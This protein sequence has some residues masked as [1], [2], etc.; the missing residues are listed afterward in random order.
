M[1]MITSCRR[2][3][4]HFFKDPFFTME[5]LWFRNK[6]TKLVLLTICLV[7]IFVKLHEKNSYM[8]QTM[9]SE[10]GQNG[11]KVTRKDTRNMIGQRSCDPKERSEKVRDTYEKRIQ[12]A[13]DHCLE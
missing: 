8:Q 12:I 11:L 5:Q 3:V 9:T 7:F 2:K 1:L 10:I 6:N 13:G 4:T